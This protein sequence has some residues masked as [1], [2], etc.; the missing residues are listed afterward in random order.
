MRCMVTGATGFI[1][2]HLVPRLIDQS[3]E[4]ACLIRDENQGKQLHAKAVP[5]VVDA[6][7]PESIQR[8]VQ[9]FSPQV[10]FHLATHYPASFDAHTIPKLLDANILFGSL[11][12]QYAVEQGT[13]CFIAA[14][15]TMQH[16]EG[17]DDRPSNFYAATKSCFDTV[18]DYY[19]DHHRA[20]ACT[21]YIFDSYGLDDPRPK[22]F[23][24]LMT[25]RPDE[26]AMRLTDGTQRIG[27]VHVDDICSGFLLAAQRMNGSQSTG[28]EK[29]ALPA[30]QPVS[31][32]ELAVLIEAGRSVK[33]PLQWGAVAQRPGQIM[34]PYSP[35]PVLPGWTE[36][37]ELEQEIRTIATHDGSPS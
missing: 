37:K 28:H 22:L 2:S 13:Q 5:Y 17:L 10:I 18:L 20:R 25:I 12:M 34:E 23:N 1:G 36:A 9:A 29:Y 24:R 11:L 16:H 8:A 4:V 30:A 14:G 26:Q 35:Y 3:Y 19:V 7:R 15:S 27:L 33:L 32:R 21:L 6:H 31:L